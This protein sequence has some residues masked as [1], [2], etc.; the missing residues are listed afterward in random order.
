MPYAE[1]RYAMG[2]STFKGQASLMKNAIFQDIRHMAKHFRHKSQRTNHSPSA[3]IVIISQDFP[4][5]LSRKIL[6]RWVIQTK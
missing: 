2:K 4:G 6:L 3:P 5:F 1:P